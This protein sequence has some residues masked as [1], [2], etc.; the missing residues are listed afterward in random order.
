MQI[1]QIGIALQTAFARHLVYR[2]VVAEL[3]AHTDR[4]LAD[5]GLSRRDIPAFARRAAGKAVET[6]Q[7]L[8]RQPH[9]HFV[10]G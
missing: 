4:Q 8:T 5:F 10:H 2:R 9:L 6:A 1:A 3:A 7:A